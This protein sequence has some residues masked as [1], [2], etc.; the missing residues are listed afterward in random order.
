MKKS[1]QKV[2]EGFRRCDEMWAEA[3]RRAQR[4]EELAK[5]ALDEIATLEARLKEFEDD[6]RALREAVGGGQGAGAPEPARIVAERS[7]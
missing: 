4:A 7:V 6:V 2:K 5:H 3:E 1:A